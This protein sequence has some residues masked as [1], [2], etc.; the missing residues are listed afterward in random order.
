MFK[1]IIL[2]VNYINLM[3]CEYYAEVVKEPEYKNPYYH[4]M[5]VASMTLVVLFFAY[6]C[7]LII[8]Y[9]ISFGLL[10]IINKII[11]IFIIYYVICLAYRY[12]IYLYVLDKYNTAEQAHKKE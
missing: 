6:I 4:E 1:N 7:Q 5:D 2:Y 3:S 9:I 8:L 12:I 10:K 11:L